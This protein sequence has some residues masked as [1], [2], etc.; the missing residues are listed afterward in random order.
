[1]LTKKIKEGGISLK[2]QRDEKD[3]ELHEC[4]DQLLRLR[5]EFENYKKQLDRQYCENIKSANASLINDLLPVLDTFE[6]A[7][8]EIKKKDTTTAHGVELIYRDMMK[9][10]EQ[11]GLKSFECIGKKLDPYFH[12]VMIQEHSDKEDGTVLE[13]LQ[14]GYML[15]GKV[16]RHSKVKIS[17]SQ[18]GGN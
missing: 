17:K 9:I 7:I 8:N 5:A 12:E 2:K 6:I 11:R 13:E 16:I 3:K 1:M 10:L 14:R 4:K 18:S 15:N